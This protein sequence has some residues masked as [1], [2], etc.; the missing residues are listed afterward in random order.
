MT[1]DLIK[2][3]THNKVNLFL[4]DPVDAEE[5]VYQI[6]AEIDT[7]TSKAFLL[8]E[9]EWSEL[10]RVLAERGARVCGLSPA[11]YLGGFIETGVMDEKDMPSKGKAKKEKA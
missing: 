9:H 4:E 10:I 8:S 7:N 1:E 11:E 6:R 5:G 3:R 2:I